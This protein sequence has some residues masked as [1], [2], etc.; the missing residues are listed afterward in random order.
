M[1]TNEPSLTQTQDLVSIVHQLISIL[2]TK[3]QEVIKRRYGIKRP[4]ETL[5]AIGNDF[6]VTRERIRQIQSYGLR[7]LQR[8]VQKTNLIELKNWT[9]QLLKESG[10]IIPESTYESALRTKYSQYEKNIAELKLAAILFEEIQFEPN[11]INFAPHFRIKGLKFETIKNLNQIATKILKKVGEPLTP[12]KILSIIQEE[13]KQSNVTFRKKLILAAIKLD[14][15]IK[16][17]ADSISLI[18]W[19]H[20]NPKTLYDKILFVLRKH[21]TPI[22]FSEI[23]NTIIQENF[24]IKSV[25]QQAVHNELIN[26]EDF[27]LVGRGVYALREWG[28]KEGTVKDVLTRILK[29]EG[30]LAQATLIQKVLEVR[31]VKPIT[32]QININNKEHFKKT[33]DNLIT[34]A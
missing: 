33:P 16:V 32:I 28:F 19:R 31:K 20:I 12:N 2:N 24:D 13:L 1:P 27:V 22:H 5:A 14:R 34:L 17:K 6:S 3:E 26:K 29:K 25:S 7:K 9:I 15:R 23:T 8:N 10:D 21:E 4:K 30:A 11:K 18:S